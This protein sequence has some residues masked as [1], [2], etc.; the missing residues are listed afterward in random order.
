MHVD[1][2]MG[3]NSKICALLS[4]FQNFNMGNYVTRS[5]ACFILPVSDSWTSVR[6]NEPM[7]R[8]NHRAFWTQIPDEPPS[9]AFAFQ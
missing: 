2:V 6:K 3:Q 9:K 8:F 4:I 5:N 7:K 1:A